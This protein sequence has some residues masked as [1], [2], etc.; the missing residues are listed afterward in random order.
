VGNKVCGCDNTNNRFGVVKCMLVIEFTCLVDVCDSGDTWMDLSNMICVC[1]IVGNTMR[2]YV[3]NSARKWRV[4]VNM[5]DTMGVY[6]I[7]CI[8]V[9]VLDGTDDGI[10]AECNRRDSVDV[11]VILSIR[12]VRN[13]MVVIRMVR[14][15]MVVIRMVVNR[16]ASRDFVDVAIGVVAV[17][18]N[19]GR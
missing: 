17:V 7:S 5:L 11:V 3:F 8:T 2:I 16:R 10:I 19:R 4:S 12:M 1:D 15:S 9:N 14:N 13:S 6:V 18:P